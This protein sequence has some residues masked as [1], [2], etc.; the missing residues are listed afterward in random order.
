MTVIGITGSIGS[1][2]STVVRLIA[3]KKISFF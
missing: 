3:K 1:G 2:K